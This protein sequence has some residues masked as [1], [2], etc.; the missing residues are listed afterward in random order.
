MA[1]IGNYSPDD[2]T[3]VLSV[4]GKNFTHRITGF[5]EGSFISM[6]RLV[7]TSIPYQGVGEKA[8]GR[9]KR[10]LTSLSV[11][12]T[13]SQ[14]S[15]SNDVLQ[16]L[17]AADAQDSTSNEWVFSCTMAD[18]SGTHKVSTNTAIIQAPATKAFGDTI[19]SRDWVIH[20]FD[21]NEEGGGN[22]LLSEAEVASITAAGGT[23]DDRWKLSSQ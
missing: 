17:Q 11:T 13:L 23:V 9:V 1:T 21:S 8:Q 7:P 2:Y 4:P 18:L 10:K 19:D 15:S 16:A 12:I 14:L 3:V 20:M 6:E 5:S 22:M